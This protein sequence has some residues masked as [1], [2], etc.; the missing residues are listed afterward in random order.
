MSYC[1]LG[2][3]MQMVT[4]VVTTLTFMLT[5]WK[6]TRKYADFHHPQ[7]LRKNLEPYIK[8]CTPWQTD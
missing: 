4:V 6:S 2:L 5:H 1:S 8:G 3:G 7:W